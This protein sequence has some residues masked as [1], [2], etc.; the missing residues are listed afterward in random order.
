MLK[1]IRNTLS[2]MKIEPLKFV[3][4]LSQFLIV[5]FPSVFIAELPLHCHLWK[6][7]KKRKIL[8]CSKHTRLRFT[9]QTAGLL[10]FKCQVFI[11]SD[12]YEC[13][14]SFGISV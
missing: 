14:V 3:L 11:V 6:K 7:K 8:T 5:T 9:S 2:L 1:Q 12:G 10:L 4:H 13:R